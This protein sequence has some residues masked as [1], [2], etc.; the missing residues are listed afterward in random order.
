M[1]VHPAQDL[2]QKNKTLKAV[3]DW[4]ETQWYNVFLVGAEPKSS[5]RIDR[6]RKKGFVH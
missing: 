6:K 4:K 1:E 2:C 5:P 3:K